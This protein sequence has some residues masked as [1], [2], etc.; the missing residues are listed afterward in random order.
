MPCQ[1]NVS[2][3]QS[4]D[5]S[6]QGNDLNLD[7]VSSQLGIVTS[8]QTTCTRSVNQAN[9]C[10]TTLANGGSTGSPGGSVSI[11]TD[12]TGTSPGTFYE[13]IDYGPHL[14]ADSECSGVD[15]V[16][17][18]YI[19]GPAL[20]GSNQRS[21]TVTITTTDYPGY[22]AK[23]CATTSKPFRVAA[24]DG[25]DPYEP[26]ADSDDFTMAVPVTQP[27]GTAGYAGLLPDCTGG[28]RPT[29]DCQTWP[30]VVSRSTNGNVHTIVASFPA[31][32]DATLRN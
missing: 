16:H 13:S 15:S 27:D 11:T 31:G 5:Y 22:T 9:S 4:N 6:G 25:D 18:E 8:S 12:A 20:N 14:S 10:S 29:V 7:S 24:P 21:F 23:L 1:W 3:K 26:V 32:F 2:G 28:A 30:G 19:S 17:D